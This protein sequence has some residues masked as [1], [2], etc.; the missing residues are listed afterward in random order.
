V[1]RRLRDA[2]L[3]RKLEFLVL[4]TCGVV[5]FCAALVFSIGETLSYRQGF[6]DD[7]GVLADIVGR[8]TEAAITFNDPKAAAESLSAL[9]GQPHILAAYVF[10]PDVDRP[11]ASYLSPAL[12]A[13]ARTGSPALSGLSREAGEGWNRGLT[14]T[15]VR[16]VLRGGERVS[17]VAI[18]ADMHELLD[19]LSWFFGFIVAFTLVS[20]AAVWIVFNRL[21]DTVTGPI[22]RLAGVMG[23]LAEGRDYS[24]R[25]PVESRD[26]I[27]ALCEG[28]ND[29]I[30]E[31]RAREEALQRHRD[32]LELRVAE[33]TAELVKATI[34]AEAANVAK[35]EFL[36]NMSH[37]IRT[38]M[39]GVIGMTGLLL[40]TELSNEQRHF[41]E[42]VRGSAESLLGLINDILDFSKIEAGKLDFETIDFDLRTTMEDVAEMMAVRAHEK[43]LRL[44]SLVD[45]HVPSMLRGDPGRVRQILLNLCGNAVKFTE[46]GEISVAVSLVS[47]DEGAVLLR[48]SVTDTG[49]GI[50]ADRVGALFSPF[51]QADGSTTRK[52]GGTGLGLAISRQ[53]A[54]R[55]GGSAGV[56]SEPGRGSVFWFT[57]RLEKQPEENLPA[58]ETF[59][60]LDGVRV[61]VVD[62][63][64]ANRLLVSTLL[65]EWGCRGDEA[66][67]GASAIARLREAAAAGDP[68]RIAL[69]DMMMPGMDGGETAA[70][71]KGDPALA[72]TQLVLLTSLGRRGDAARATQL[73]MSGYLSK[74]IRASQLRDLLSMLLGRKEGDPVRPSK[75]LVTRHT[76]LE[77]RKGRIRILLVEDNPTNQ[78]VAR[79]ILRK[80]GYSAEVASN[81]REALDAL[82]RTAFHLVLMDCQMPVMDG[83]E[84]TRRIRA[85]EGRASGPKVPVV[86]MTA[87]AMQGDRER[88]VEAGMDDYL[89]KPV[90]PERLAEALDR[91]L[92]QPGEGDR[93]LPDLRLADGAPP[94]PAAQTEVFDE[95]S[96]VARFM[97]DRALAKEVVPAFLEEIPVLMARMVAC[98]KSGDAEGAGRQAHTIKGAAGNVSAEALRRVAEEIEKAG[99]A[100]DTAGVTVRLPRLEKQFERLSAVLAD[101]G[102]V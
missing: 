84:A 1:I 12:E 63:H 62:D 74:P 41:A 24:V 43:G 75:R 93:E 27:G 101:T 21:Q 92:A 73:G 82:D 38:P 53:L 98:A 59:A 90:Q 66:I 83:F 60:E 39:N 5:I 29:M 76:V 31:I 8:N 89:T 50:P 18:R 100:G 88:C 61:L 11:F 51:V 15:V 3:K 26:E 65:R 87:N 14:L 45:P 22:T 20:F 4:A 35:S 42:I 37:E 48:F 16:P 10:A 56:E 17:T 78:L 44:A 69:L 58:A 55:M 13:D 86:A 28:F 68:F 36:A 19:K 97:G 77:S 40:D 85:G 96:M 57:A 99:L 23:S 95:E 72:Q 7:L 49:I 81:G 54:E 33:R 34:A 94:P 6:R 47:E 25:V 79:T 9:N 71:I 64:A 70:T 67:D 2:P 46:K 30:E 52:Y 32:A 102:W 80:L 91:W